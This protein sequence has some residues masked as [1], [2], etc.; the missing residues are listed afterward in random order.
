MSSLDFANELF[1]KYQQAAAS[2]SALLL[3]DSPTSPFSSSSIAPGVSSSRALNGYHLHA[4]SGRGNGGLPS[5]PSLSSSSPA[6]S[7][8]STSSSS[9][10]SLSL[11]GLN[12]SCGSAQP[13]AHPINPA[14]VLTGGA[15]SASGAAPLCSSLQ[16]CASAQPPGRPQLCSLTARLPEPACRRQSGA[17]QQRQ[18]ME[19]RLRIYPWMR[20]SGEEREE[21][22]GRGDEVISKASQ[23]T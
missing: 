8:P 16:G 15:Y 18:L 2:C 3:T 20:S 7:F 19:E 9:W 17:E 22:D 5:P 12:R 14:E 13:G 6:S 10:S 11:S 4:S 21:E 23:V 1:S